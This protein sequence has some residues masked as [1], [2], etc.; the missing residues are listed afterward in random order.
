V[1][2]LARLKLSVSCIVILQKE[3]GELNMDMTESRSP[4]IQAKQPW[5]R[6]QPKA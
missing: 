6:S 2:R 5:N 3:Y 1:L 4:V